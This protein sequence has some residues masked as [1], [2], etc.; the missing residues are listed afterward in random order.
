[1]NRW[2]S[3]RSSEAV[4]RAAS[5]YFLPISRILHVVADWERAEYR[6]LMLGKLRDLQLQMCAD[7][8]NLSGA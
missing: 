5:F 7:F 6:V 3:E 1:L 4:P 2:Q 8:D